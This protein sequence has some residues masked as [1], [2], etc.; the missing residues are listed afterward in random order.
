MA[1]EGLSLIVLRVGSV[2]EDRGGGG[3]GPGN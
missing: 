2:D 3:G 1:T